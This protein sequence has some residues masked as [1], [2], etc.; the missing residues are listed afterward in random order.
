[1]K[2]TMSTLAAALIAASTCVAGTAHAQTSVTTEPTQQGHVTEIKT[3]DTT[4]R[5]ST[6]GA[7]SV[8][9]VSVNDQNVQF[10][11]NQAPRMVGGRVMVPLRGVIERLGGSV[12]YEAKTQ[13]ITGANAQTGSQ[14]RMRLG[15]NEVV[16][17]GE[18]KTLDARPQVIA[19][20]TYVPLRFVSEALGAEVAWDNATRTVTIEA[21]GNT[22]QVKAG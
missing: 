7:G 9:S 8:I 13:V 20:T 5:V 17:N 16:V 14:F 19:G 2:Q 11:E 21:A 6:S 15:S 12:L 10:A 3:P 4:T 22:A 18:N 1:M